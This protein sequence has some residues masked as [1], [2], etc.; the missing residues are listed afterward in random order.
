MLPVLVLRV[1]RLSFG[2]TSTRPSLPLLLVSCDR[3]VTLLVV[4]GLVVVQHAGMVARLTFFASPPHPPSP[5]LPSSV[6]FTCIC[7][8]LTALALAARPETDS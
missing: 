3:I 1:A 5:L 8:W 4:V 2:T 7:T 6:H